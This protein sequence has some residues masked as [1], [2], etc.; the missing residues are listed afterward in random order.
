MGII[1]IKELKNEQ[2]ASFADVV[3]SHYPS[4]TVQELQEAKANGNLLVGFFESDQPAGYMELELAED[5]VCILVRLVILPNFRRQSFGRAMLDYA[6][7]RSEE[8]GCSKVRAELTPASMPARVWLEK[9]GFQQIG[10]FILEYDI[11]R[12]QHTCCTQ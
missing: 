5:R 8:S 2:I 1:M 10:E 4:V 6:V 9:Y 7:F 12:K 11:A 3:R